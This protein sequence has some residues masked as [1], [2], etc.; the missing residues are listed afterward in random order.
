MASMSVATRRAFLALMLALVAIVTA[1]PARAEGVVVV[2]HDPSALVVFRGELAPYGT[3][4]EHPTYGTVWVPHERAVGPGFAPY[5][6]QGRWALAD[7]GDWMW[8]SDYPFGWVVFHYGRWVWSS[9][10]GWVWIPGREYAHA[11]VVWR[12]PVAHYTFV[13]WAPAPPSYYWY[14]GVAVGLWHRPTVAYVFCDSR[15]VFHHHVHHHVV[16]QPA[17][18]RA[19]AAGTLRYVPSAGVPRRGPSMTQAR[20]PAAQVPQAR[21]PA[22]PR[23]V[24]LRGRPAAGVR[25]PAH[26]RATGGA[27]VTR[28]P[29]SR[30]LGSTYDTRRVAPSGAGQ[31]SIAAG[32]RPAARPTTAVAPRPRQSGAAPSRAG[33]FEP[34]PLV[35]RREP[36]TVVAPAPAPSDSGRA[37][38]RSSGERTAPSSSSATSSR[39]PVRPSA[40]PG[41]SSS[42][43]RSS[44]SRSNSGRS[45]RS[46]ARPSRR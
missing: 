41:A 3:W 46:P 22:N 38:S 45:S 28:A 25:P 2:D 21:T 8:V 23:A 40:S 20:V 15:Y 27:S 43:P 7:D 36:A 11:W 30:S 1:L 6:T 35:T 17:T 13:G 26:P 9:D 34:S 37:S 14:G 24:A 32:T 29:V 16:R 12:T 33:D 42:S 18:V 31:S 4:V 44:S 39:R 10:H 5:V 19:A